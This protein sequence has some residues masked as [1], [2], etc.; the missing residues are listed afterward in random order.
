MLRKAIKL[1]FILI[2]LQVHAVSWQEIFNFDFSYLDK[3][4]YGMDSRV[5]VSEISPFWQERAENVGAMIRVSK[6]NS[7]GALVSQNNGDTHS[8]CHDEKFYSEPVVSECSGFL[9]SPD[10]LI[11]AGHCYQ[12]MDYPYLNN[13]EA[14]C[15]DF[16]WSFDYTGSDVDVTRRVNIGDIYRCKEVIKI[17]FSFASDFAVV[18]LDR[19]VTDRKGLKTLLTEKQLTGEEQLTLI[20]HP[21]GLP[22]KVSPGGKIL[23]MESGANIFYSS[24]NSFHGSSGAPVFNQAGVVVGLLISGKED[25]YFDRKEMCQRVNTCSFDGKSCTG[26]PDNFDGEGIF[27]ITKVLELLSN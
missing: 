14:V 24:L 4:I 18:K 12:G 1:F 7:N 26:G 17:D 3:V 5:N 11:T 8:L 25:Y 27:K 23:K 15:K 2:N 13:E 9:I 10:T 21:G 16:V 6:I 19:P 22:K 20:S